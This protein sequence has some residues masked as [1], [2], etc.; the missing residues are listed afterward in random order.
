MLTNRLP[1]AT[2]G[3]E[4]GVTGLDSQLTQST[5]VNDRLRSNGKK[6]V[7]YYSQVAEDS[8]IGQV[9]RSLPQPHVVAKRPIE[10]ST[11][12]PSLL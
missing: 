4:F 3:Q 5:D 2:Y 11:E 9:K 8:R 10:R 1:R 12:K 6:S 7:L